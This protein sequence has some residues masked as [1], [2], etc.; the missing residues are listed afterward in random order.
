[1]SSPKSGG[2]S[3][4]AIVFLAILVCGGIVVVAFVEGVN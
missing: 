1:M 4:M 3:T 2:I